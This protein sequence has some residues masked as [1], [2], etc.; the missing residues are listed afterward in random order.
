[1]Q[2]RRAAQIENRR[3]VMILVGSGLAI[4][5]G[6][7]ALAML[8]RPPR[9]PGNAC[10]GGVAT[11]RVLILVDH[12]DPWSASSATLLS[13]HLRRIA[14]SAAT[15]DRLVMMAFN[16]S[17]SRLPEPVF[18]RCKLPSSGN[19]LFETPGKLAKDHSTQFATPLLAALETLSKPASA[20]RT[21][22]VQMLAA[23]A[24]KTRLDASASSITMHVFSDMDENSGGFSFARK[25]AQS[26]EKFTEHF[27]VQIGNRLKDFDL[28]IHVMPPPPSSTR[29]NQRGARADPR[30]E[31]AWRAAFAANQIRYTWE[32]L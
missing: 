29:G 4:A 7:G 13:A 31:R 9:Q 20:S 21:E 15:E 6:G 3:S 26:Q 24:T 30:I 19:V 32:T 16:G 28:R 12:T 8:R 23:I 25:P 27:T 14:A 2:H 10:I 5:T 22:L 11:R 1:M 17:A 18:D